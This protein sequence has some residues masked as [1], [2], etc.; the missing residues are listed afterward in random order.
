[1]KTKDN[2]KKGRFFVLKEKD[3]IH[4]DPDADDRYPIIDSLAVPGINTPQITPLELDPPV[5]NRAWTAMRLGK[6]I[7][8]LTEEERR[9]LYYGKD[10]II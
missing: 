8:A 4:V 2:P 1:M 5:P 6:D 10:D 3:Y 9:M 7:D